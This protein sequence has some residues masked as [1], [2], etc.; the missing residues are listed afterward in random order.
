VLWS[1]SRFDWDDTS[2]WW[3]ATQ[4]FMRSLTPG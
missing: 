3:A 4:E 2:G 1:P